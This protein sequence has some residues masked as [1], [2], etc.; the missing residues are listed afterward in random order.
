MSEIS[1]RLSQPFGKYGLGTVFS[2]LSIV[3]ERDPSTYTRT[4]YTSIQIKKILNA[5]P[6]NNQQLVMHIGC[7]IQLFDPTQSI[8]DPFDAAPGLADSLDPIANLGAIAAPVYVKEEFDIDDDSYQNILGQLIRWTAVPSSKFQFRVLAHTD[9]TSLDRI[10]LAIGNGDVTLESAEAVDSFKC[11]PVTTDPEQIR[12][13]ILS[14]NYTT[15]D[16]DEEKLESADQTALKKFA[17]ELINNSVVSEYA[18]ALTKDYQASQARNGEW[19]AEEWLDDI[20]EFDS[21]G[22]WFVP[23]KH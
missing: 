10:N 2:N 14:K 17:S 13:I 11:V 6:I 21:G 3:Q 5:Q 16:F 4:P 8:A 22:F 19:I 23:D 18:A 12:K 15:Y 7:N 9:G 1:C 20:D